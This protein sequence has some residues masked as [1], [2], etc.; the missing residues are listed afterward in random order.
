MDATFWVEPGIVWTEKLWSNIENQEAEEIAA[1]H[2]G[3]Q[4]YLDS[5]RPRPDQ[6]DTYFCCFKG[7]RPTVRPPTF[8]DLLAQHTQTTPQPVP[9]QRW[10]STTNWKDVLELPKED[11]R[12]VD[13][14]VITN[15]RWDAWS[16]LD[17][18]EL[19]TGQI[20][21]KIRQLARE[22]TECLNPE[23]KFNLRVAQRDGPRRLEIYCE[24]K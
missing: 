15:S 3:Y 14:K 5:R 12:I 11:L 13:L 23:G 4:V 22:S 16:S 21:P 8:A 1:K 17:F 20:L 2:V 6:R 24:L 10:Q 7:Q 9:K 18:S 19:E